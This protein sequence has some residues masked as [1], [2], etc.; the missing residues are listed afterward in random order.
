MRNSKALLFLMF[1]KK[2]FPILRKENLIKQLLVPSLLLPILFGACSY[3][4]SDKIINGSQAP[5]ISLP[6]INGQ[7]ITLS[8]FKGKIVLV[9]FWA[10]WCKPC[11]EENPRV[12]AL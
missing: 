8:S 10:S 6:D 5:E 9:Q 3:F 4:N 7:P 1:G 11:R 12:V 2:G